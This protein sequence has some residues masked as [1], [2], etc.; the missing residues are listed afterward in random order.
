MSVFT[1]IVTEQGELVRV[2]GAWERHKRIVGYRNLAEKTFLALGEELYHFEDKKQY[3]DLGHDTFESYLADPDVDIARRTA[4]MLIGV[5]D[6]YVNKYASASDALLKAGYTK[7]DVIRP[8]VDESNVD[9]WVHKAATLSRSDLKKEIGDS[10]WW[11]S[12]KD[13]DW[14]T[15][16]GLF[17]LLDSEFNFELDV[18]ASDENHK[19]DRY[20]TRKDDGLS[21]VW[22]G[23]CYMNPPYGRTGGISIYEWV[24]KAYQS[25]LNGATVVCL[26]PARTDTR[27]WWDYCI[28]GEVRFL[29]GRLKFGNSGGSAPFPSA[30]VVFKP[31]VKDAGVVWW[32]VGWNE[33]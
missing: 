24:Q 20:F 9:E 14:W 19:C 15:P 7:L 18:C 33:E 30:V 6:T 10:E 27:W 1:H 13:D 16:Q 2:D 8:H 29:K 12:S 28:K 3:K 31:G 21:Q 26:V 5:Y 11:Q 25:A 23:V 22:R 32:G 4:Y 17:D